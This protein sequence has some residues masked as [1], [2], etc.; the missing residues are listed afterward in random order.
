M[1][2][3]LSTTPALAADILNTNNSIITG[4][5][6]YVGIFSPQ[7]TATATASDTNSSALQSFILPANFLAPNQC[8]R[9]RGAGTVA[10]NTHAKSLSLTLVQGTTTITAMSGNG[11][12]GTANW[13]A[14]LDI[15]C[16]GTAAESYYGNISMSAGGTD[17]ASVYANVNSST[18]LSLSSA[19]TVNLTGKNGTAAASDIV[20]TFFGAELLK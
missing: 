8:I 20:S 18:T 19:I 9:L 5:N 15:N 6:S 13:T 14:T 16:T 10:S 1:Q 3:P 17:A 12:I 11:T 4:I 2:Y 7:G